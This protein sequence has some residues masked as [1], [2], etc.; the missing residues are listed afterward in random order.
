MSTVQSIVSTWP[1][2]LTLEPYQNLQ[3]HQWQKVATVGLA[4]ILLLGI[5]LSCSLPVIVGV[6]FL[7]TVTTLLS[8]ALLRNEGGTDSNWCN[9]NF[10]KKDMLID[11]ALRLIAIPIIV[12]LITA[13]GFL[14]LQAVAI[15]IMNRNVR[16]ILLATVI[17]PIAEEIIFRGFLQERFEDLAIL[18][19]RYIHPLSEEIKMGFSIAAQALIFGAMHITGSQIV[20]KS[21]KI[22]VFLKTSLFGAWLGYCKQRDASLLS[23]IAIHSAHNTGATLGMLFGKLLAKSA[24]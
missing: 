22:I 1:R 5:Q 18:V 10:N 4:C 14:P 7:C 23:P 24:S 17:A 2:A 16:I 20:Q 13:S 6:T 11:V 19:D 12:G 15:A 9:V 21:S 3:R 8:E